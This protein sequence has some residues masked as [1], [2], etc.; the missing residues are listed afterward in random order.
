MW[1]SNFFNRIA[2]LTEIRNQTTL[3]DQLTIDEFDA[4]ILI[5]FRK[6]GP[7]MSTIIVITPP[8]G[9]ISLNLDDASSKEFMRSMEKLF[10]DVVAARA[11]IECD[12]GENQHRQALDAGHRASKIFKTICDDFVDAVARDALI[13]R[14]VIDQGGECFILE[15][16]KTGKQFYGVVSGGGSD[17]RHYNISGENLLR[18]M[19]FVVE[20][21]RRLENKDKERLRRHTPHIDT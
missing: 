15:A 5:E 2:G 20:V 14:I 17:R 8:V 12:K 10:I 13:G 6:S 7:M 16:G 18:M 21:G 9:I 4:N 3:V 19:Q 11:V 1:F